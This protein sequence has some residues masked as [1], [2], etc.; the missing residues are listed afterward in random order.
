[1]MALVADVDTDIVEQGAVLQPLALAVREAVH[2]AG[3]IENAQGEPRN[4]LRVLRPVAAA[5]AELEHAATPY[6]RIS[7]HLA[8]PRAVTVNVVEDQP[9]AKREIAQCQVLGPQP[10][11]DRVEQHRSGDAQVSTPRIQAGDSQPL[12]DVRCDEALAQPM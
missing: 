4:L 1:M 2:A 9:F 8:Y 5:L 3:L 12:F 7:L 10:A 11:Q 6:V